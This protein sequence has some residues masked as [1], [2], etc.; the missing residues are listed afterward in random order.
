MPVYASV[1]ELHCQLSKSF[2]TNSSAHNMNTRNNFYL[3]RPNVNIS[4]FQKSTFCGGIK[5]L[6]SFPRNLE[7]L[8]NENAEFNEALR[9]S[10]NTHH[11]VTL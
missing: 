5:I 7:V 4:Y 10:L 8:K 3:H 11:R 2:Q 9:K 1:N 6:N